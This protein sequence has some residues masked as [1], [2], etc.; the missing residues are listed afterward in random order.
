M[1]RSPLFGSR[2]QHSSNWGYYI[3]PVVELTVELTLVPNSWFH[4]EP[5]VFSMVPHGS[6]LS[7]P[8]LE[9][10]PTHGSKGVFFWNLWN[11][12][13]PPQINILGRAGQ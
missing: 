1:N 5:L 12:I 10:V 6:K 13:Y 4:L 8:N 11:H 2:F 3:S 9:L 7:F